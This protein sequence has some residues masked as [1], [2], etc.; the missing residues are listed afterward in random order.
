MQETAT[1]LFLRLILGFFSALLILVLGLG[2]FLLLLFLLPF[3]LLASPFIVFAV[4][5][6]SLPDT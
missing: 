6:S 5:V 3:I 1:D 4:W 2:A